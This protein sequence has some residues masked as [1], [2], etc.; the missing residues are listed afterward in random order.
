L[1]YWLAWKAAALFEVQPHVSALYLSAGLT[2]AVGMIGG[3]RHLPAAFLAICVVRQ[4]DMPGPLLEGID[5]GGALR[6]VLVYGGTGLLLRRRWLA[7]PARLTLADAMHVVLLAFAATSVSAAATLFIP[8]FDTLPASELGAVFLSFW[9]GDF[10]GLLLGLPA[11]VLGWN[12]LLRGNAEHGQPDDSP[13]APIHGL[14]SRTGLLGLA[15]GVSLLTLLLPQLTHS[16]AKLGI[17]ILFP[18]LLA[19][20]MRGV[21]MGYLVAALV[22]AIQILAG[23]LLGLPVDG[24]LD[25]QLVLAMSAATAL[26]AG[27]AH[28]DKHFEWQHANFDLLTGLA[29]RHRFQDQLEHELM[30]AARTQQPLALM[31][32][33]LDGFKAVND[34]L[35]HH[36]G[37]LL[38]LQVAGRLRN[39]VRETDTVARLGGDEFAIILPDL[40]E[41]AI[42]DRIGHTLL[43]RLQQPFELD[44]RTAH[45]SAS[46]GVALWP[47]DG[48]TPTDLIHHADRAM[49]EAKRLGRNRLA[50][51]ASIATPP[52]LP[53]AAPAGA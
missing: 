47:R 22:C 2:T 9:G 3:W 14:R 24:V 52:D 31:Y 21:L 15:L 33:D 6:Q 48:R 43:E 4:L 35:G 39:C 53:A 20:L 34:S 38:L 37:D 42:I 51:H 49:Y 10:A 7:M 18:V 17:L 23:R 40:K 30:R 45:I 1:C 19:G 44:G 27:A 25:L 46:I 28:D 50:H 29:N 11:I 13:T 41:L 36:A 5:W 12:L 8:P 16:E 32:I 26:L